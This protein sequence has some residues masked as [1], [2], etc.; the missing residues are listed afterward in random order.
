MSVEYSR[1][2]THLEAQ[3]LSPTSPMSAFLPDGQ[4]DELNA[5]RGIVFGVLASVLGCAAIAALL[6][7]IV[8]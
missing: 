2:D 6:W 8:G 4:N 1:F 3:G 5:A 7:L